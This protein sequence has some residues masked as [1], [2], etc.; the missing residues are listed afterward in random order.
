MTRQEYYKFREEQAH[1]DLVRKYLGMF[2]EFLFEYPAFKDMT[3]KEC[4][5]YFSRRQTEI[6]NE[7]EKLLNVEQ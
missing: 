6:N 7:I 3:A 1:L 2:D 5:E 4:F